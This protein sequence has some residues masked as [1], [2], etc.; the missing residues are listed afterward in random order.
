MGSNSRLNDNDSDA[1]PTAPPTGP[2]TAPRLPSVIHAEDYKSLKKVSK[3]RFYKEI[4]CLQMN[5]KGCN[6]E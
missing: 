4:N 5:A 2:P 3:I 1:L 6:C